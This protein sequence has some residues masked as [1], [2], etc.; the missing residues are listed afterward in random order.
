MVECA[1]AEKFRV[2]NSI[3]WAKSHAKLPPGDPRATP[4]RVRDLEQSRSWV[5]FSERVVFAESMSPP[6]NPIAERVRA[7]RCAAGLSR[8]KLAVAIGRTVKDDPERG[9]GLVN[10]WEEG[11]CTPSEEDWCRLFEVCGDTRTRA[12][13][14][15]ERSY[16]W[17][18]Y[19]TTR[20]PFRAPSHQ[21]TDVWTYATALSDPTRHLCEKPRDMLI[22]VVNASS[23]SGDLV[24][25]LFG[26]SFRMAEVALEA[27][28]HYLGCDI[29]PEWVARGF[30]RA[31]AQENGTHAPVSPRKPKTSDERQGILLK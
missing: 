25:D 19:E 8:D 3:T 11:A 18:K 7:V 6:E 22:D 9:T 31:T 10:R 14:L 30:A 26:G 28:R 21:Y 17:T 2:L 27:G 24:L 12:E 15:A 5:S 4:L 1:V 13:L 16:L 23:R 29:D 20:R